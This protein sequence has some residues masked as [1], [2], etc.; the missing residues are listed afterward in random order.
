MKK[1]AEILKKEK[2]LVVGLM[3]GTSADGISAVLVEISGHSLDV[4]FKL[5]AY[6]TYPYPEEVKKALFDLFDTKKSTV[7]KISFMNFVLGELFADAAIRIAEEAGYGSSDIDLVASHGQTVYHMPEPRTMGGISTASTLQI[8]EPAVIAERTGAVTVADFRPR[9]VAAG[10]QGAP[11]IAYVDYVLFRSPKVNRAVQNIGGIANVTY[12]P[13][14][15]SLSEIVAFDTGPGNM[16]IDA[17]VRYFTGGKAEFDVD[18][19]I[20]REGRVDEGLLSWLMR[21]PFIARP[22]PKTTGREEFGQSFFK[23][24]LK[25][26]ERLGLGWKDMV[27]T[28][29]AFTA[30][31]IRYNYENFLGPIDEVILGGGGALNKTLRR[32]LEER[33]GL[34]TLTHSDFGI[35]DQAKEPLGIALLANDTIAGIP[36]SVP[37]AT[38]A[39]RRTVLGKI[40]L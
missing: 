20:A 15:A 37:S 24:V 19:K 31:A 8:G 28:L 33:L 29:T 23:E 21:H 39:R 13:R 6:R 7:D 9:D 38:G 10:G 27:A 3:S 40:V 34:P 18:G 2:R 1:L 36:N 35:P 11:I 30:E 16:L 25:V 26:S 14:N 17:A 4:K 22:P 5:L 32:M 12:L